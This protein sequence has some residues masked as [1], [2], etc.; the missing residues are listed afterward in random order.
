MILIFIKDNKKQVMHKYE[1]EF[2]ARF[3]YIDDEN[4]RKHMWDTL[5]FIT[6]ILSIADKFTAQEKKRP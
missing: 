6:N 4:L 5:E 3:S 2:E 1:S